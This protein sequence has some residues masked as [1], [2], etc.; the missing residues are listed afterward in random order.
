MF[1]SSLVYL[2]VINLNVKHNIQQHTKQLQWF[3]KLFFLKLILSKKIVSKNTLV[4]CDENHGQYR[5]DN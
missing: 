1:L 2:F 5:E 4:W 3:D